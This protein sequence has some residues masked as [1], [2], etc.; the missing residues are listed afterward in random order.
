MLLYRGALIRKLHFGM[1]KLQT[2]NL[3]FQDFGNDDPAV[4]I[5]SLILHGCLDDNKI[6]NLKKHRGEAEVA[7]IFDS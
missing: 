2:W 5:L 4:P 1:V 6:V 3:Y 7:T